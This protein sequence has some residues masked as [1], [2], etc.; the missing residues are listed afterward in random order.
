MPFLKCFPVL[1]VI[2]VL[3]ACSGYEPAERSS[4]DEVPPGKGAFSGS[5]GAFYIF[6]S[7]DNSAQKPE[8]REKR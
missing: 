6:R 2:A 4:L 8:N 7:S 1:A 3:T 5:D